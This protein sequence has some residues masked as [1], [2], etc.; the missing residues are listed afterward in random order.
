MDSPDN[1]VYASIPDNLGKIWISHNSGVSQ[2]DT[3]THQFINFTTAEGLQDEEFN[4]L[5]FFKSTNGE[6]MLGGINGLNIF[7]P[8]AVKLP[9]LNLSVRIVEATSYQLKKPTVGE[10]NHSLIQNNDGLQL[11][12]D[13]NTLRFGFFV[14]DYHDPVRYRIRYR[15][16]PFEAKWVDTDK[17]A[18]GT[19]ANLNPG[20]IRSP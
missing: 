4:R 9:E 6:I 3:Q 1:T 20:K 15:L 10:V 7:D 16:E 8:A 14:P 11:P 17:L 5:A 13:D 2:Y 19:Y 12:F 18:S